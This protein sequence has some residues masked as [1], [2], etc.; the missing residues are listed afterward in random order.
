MST[1]DATVVLDNRVN[2]SSTY[3]ELVPFTGQNVNYFSVPADGGPNFPSQIYFNNIVTPGGLNSTLVGRNIRIRYTV[4]VVCNNAV[5]AT[6]ARLAST[7]Y[8]AGTVPNLALRAFPLQS[9]C[10]TL[11]LQLNGAT[12]TI[13]S[14]QILSATQRFIPADYIK[15]QSTECPSMADNRAQLLSDPTVTLGNAAAGAQTTVLAVSNQPLSTYENSNGYTRGCFQPVFAPVTPPGGTTT[16]WTFDVS[17]PLMVSPLVLWENDVFLGQLSTM[18]LQMNYSNINDM[19]V[20]SLAAFDVNPIVSISSPVLQLCYIQTQ[21]DLVQIPASLKYDYESVVYFPQSGV[22]VGAVS[23]QTLRLQTMPKMIY[24]F[25]RDAI[26]AR[27]SFHSDSLY[28]LGNAGNGLAGVS[29]QIGS[30][31][32]L[33]ASASN[34]D[35]FRMAVS[36]GYNSTFEDWTYGS[37]T[38]YAINPCKDLGISLGSDSLP[39]QVGGNTN[40]QISL[41]V[42]STP[43]DYV[44]AAAGVTELMI[45]VVYAGDMTI[46]SDMALF[47][48]GTLS[49][50]EVD[51]LIKRN[52]S[53]VGSEIVSPTMPQ[54]AGLFARGKTI[55]GHGQAK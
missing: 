45:V 22:A 29:I 15:S 4:T 54:G 35:M 31:T 50:S 19:L 38:I 20:T 6:A 14:R 7:P 52:K 5:P 48:L 10:D 18:T 33:L 9:I 53:S 1:I 37:G 32:G 30:R 47:N 16:T 24:I 49:A 44:G 25:A 39:G 43:Q 12:T 42:N 28:G 51:S 13:N 17:E 34:K 41:T 36:N 46:T 55:V 2:V 40:F 26:T 21:P 27:N 3:T 8:I 11:S 23:S